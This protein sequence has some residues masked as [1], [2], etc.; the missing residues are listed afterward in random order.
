MVNYIINILIP[1]EM[2]ENQKCSP[3]L[4]PTEQTPDTVYFNPYLG[5]QLNI[6]SINCTISTLIFSDERVLSV[7]QCIH[8]YIYI[9][10]YITFSA[11]L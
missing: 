6:Q 5:S 2:P 7:G 9:Y 4:M 8:I 1:H 11:E 10:I 3:N